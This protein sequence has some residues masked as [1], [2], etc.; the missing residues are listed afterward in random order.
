MTPPDGSPR[1]ALI[2]ANGHGLWHRRHIAPLHDS[3]ALALVALCDVAPIAD[4]EDAPIPPGAILFTDHRELL[5]TVVPEVVVVCTP[6]HTHLAIAADA[7]RAGADVLLEKPPVTSLAEHAAL[8]KVF[9]DTGRAAQIGFQALGS[10]A[11]A[12]LLTAIRAGDLGEVTGIAAYASWQRPDSY[13]ARAP[14]AGRREVNGHPVLDGA[15]ANP[16]AHALMQS[17][18]ITAGRAGP[19]DAAEDDVCL[20][21]VEVEAYRT[22]PIE[23]D[24][25]A[26][27]RVTLPSGPRV[28]V[29]VTL[30]GEDFLPGEIIVRGTRGEA[31]L[32]YP[33]DRLTLPRDAAPV[34]VPG[35]VGLLENLLAHRADPTGV[36][37]LVPPARTAPFSAV[38]E[39]IRSGPSPTLIGAPHVAASGDGPDRVLTVTGINDVVTRAAETLSLFSELDVPWA[40]PPHRVPFAAERLFGI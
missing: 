16:F 27:L 35:R 6:P 33:T 39:A 5:R 38:I 23:V 30:C 19:S 1:V 11:L 8:A 34:A 13:Y 26:C 18:A 31:R 22:R 25:T 37:L 21:L 24:D 20:S 12:R 40:T 28:L 36:P 3:G 17:L 7:A 4:A 14:W 9:A 15:L 10:V 32:E 2:G 29:A